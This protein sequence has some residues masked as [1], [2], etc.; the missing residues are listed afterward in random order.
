[1]GEL[2]LSFLGI[3]MHVGEATGLPLGVRHRVVLVDASRG[4][5]TNKGEL[6]PHQ[7]S[8]SYSPNRVV[9]PSELAS[10]KG[11]LMP[12][13]GWRL[14]VPNADDTFHVSLDNVPKLTDFDPAMKLRYDLLAAGPPEQ[15][16]FFV[17]INHGHIRPHTFAE[18][19]D[20]GTYTSWRVHT[21]GAPVLRFEGR[22]GDSF[23][24]VFPD[25]S[26]G[27]D[28]F[29]YGIHG[30]LVLANETLDATDSELDFMLHYLAAQG[31]IPLSFAAPLPKAMTAKPR[32]A[33]PI[34]KRGL[35]SRLPADFGLSGSCSNS[36]YP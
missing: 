8:L 5:V 32:Q 25:D 9:D 20:P 10:A 16:A 17:D 18:V 28:H 6:P 7:S 22:N 12:L 30:P 23:E 26:A 11:F 1:M 34:A 19:V 21:H 14:T 15:A 33:R 31:G 4:T 24:M 29:P 3:C 36:Q 27:T 13:R 35:A 2:E